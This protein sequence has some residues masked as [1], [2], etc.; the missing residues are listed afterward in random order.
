MELDSSPT[1]S[2]VTSAT[3]TQTDTSAGQPA[4]SGSPATDSGAAVA[5]QQAAT[6]V[7]V[8]QAT[9]GSA[10]VTAPE[11]PDEQLQGLTDQARAALQARSQHI[12]SLETQLNERNAQIQQYS[13]LQSLVPVVENLGGPEVV[14]GGLEILGNIFQG[15][16][17]DAAARIFQ[18]SPQTYQQFADH[19]AQTEAAYLVN[20]LHASGALQQVLANAGL[21]VVSQDA[22]RNS[23]NA[24]ISSEELAI[25]P[26]QFHDLYRQLPAAMR[27]ELQAS[28]D[29]AR[30]W[31]LQ[32]EAKAFEFDQFQASQRAHQEQQREL[33]NH[34]AVVERKGSYFNGLETALSQHLNNWNPTGKPEL[35]TIMRSAF[36]HYAV[37]ESYN[38]PLIKSELVDV[39]DDLLE[40]G[41]VHAANRMRP[42]LSAKMSQRLNPIIK[43]LSDAFSALRQVNDSQ[44]QQQ[45]GIKEIPGQ[46]Q[47]THLP[48]GNGK[49]QGQAFRNGEMT[50]EYTAFLSR[51]LPGQ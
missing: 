34:N 51:T 50:P 2:G 25:I 31:Q 7:N 16:I 33:Q 44:R 41:E 48:S 27:A 8:E 28:D 36:V 42:Q 1:A 9:D 49:F 47:P 37:N 15:Q 10:A 4:V 40:K 3:S 20:K 14:Q 26:Q 39:I 30:M 46:G 38:D 18:E 6:D 29:D 13:A 24:P 43:D 17:P 12:K 23:V 45:Q 32:R 5:P 21:A 11:I 19:F 35:D 22:A